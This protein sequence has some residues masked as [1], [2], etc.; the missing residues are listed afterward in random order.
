M[1]ENEV[2]QILRAIEKLEHKVD[3]QHHLVVGNGSSNAVL[4]RLRELELTMVNVPTWQR[5]GEKFLTPIV[6]AISTAGLMYLLFG[7][8]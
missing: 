7:T 1:T 3:N 4:P 6:T 8:P 5:I 2:A